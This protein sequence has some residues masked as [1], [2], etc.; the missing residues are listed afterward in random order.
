MN[1]TKI[2]ATLDL[3][4]PDELADMH[5]FVEVWERAGFMSFDEAAE[6]WLPETPS[7]V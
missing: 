6:L 4:T 2:D 7:A 1:R 5:R 3:M